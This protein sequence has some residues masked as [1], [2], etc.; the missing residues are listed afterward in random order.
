MSDN[1][2]SCEHLR[3]ETWPK[4]VLAC[5]CMCPDEPIGSIRHRGR[6]IECFTRGT[7]GTVPRP[8]WCPRQT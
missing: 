5:R 7:V 1:C 3:A 6:V 2:N 8:A 4:G